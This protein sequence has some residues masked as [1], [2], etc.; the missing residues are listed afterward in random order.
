MDIAE[1]Y[2]EL[3]KKSLINEIYIEN[4]IKLFYLLHCIVENRPP[5]AKY[6]VNPETIPDGLVEAVKNGKDL[7]QTVTLMV[8]DHNGQ[9]QPAHQL[10]NYAEFPHSMIGR[11]RMDNLQYCIEKVLSDNIPGDFIE[12]GVWRGGATIFMRGVLAAYNISD[13]V[14]WVA[15][16]FEG[17]PPSALVQDRGINLTKEQFPV[18][19]VGLEKVKELFERY[20][21]LDDQV[22]FLK[23]WF[24]DTLPI[25]P[26]EKL[27]IL[28]LDGDLYE[29]TMDAFNALYDKVSI[30]GIIIIDDYNALRVCKEAVHDFRK[31]NHIDDKMVKI[32]NSSIYWIKS[33][34]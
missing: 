27:S 18:L 25:A 12:T 24:K 6:L 31:K 34:R 4:E 15:D 20:N 8:K 22:K 33:K 14:I 28:R 13:R 5:S 19:S 3:L 32:D 23:G 7:G 1:R 10:R 17:L 30:G 29:S 11:K 21:L 16:S 26:I 9:K 2:I